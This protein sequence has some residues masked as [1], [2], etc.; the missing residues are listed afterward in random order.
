MKNNQRG[1]T[2]VETMFM[3][4]I[5]P[6]IMMAVYSVLSSANTIMSTNNVYSRLNTDA[7]QT[8]R[9]VAREIGQTSPNALPSHLVIGV[10]AGQS[11]VRFQIPVDWDNDGDVVNGSL[12]PT[13][14]WGSYS[15]VRDDTS[16][17]GDA[18]LNGWIRYSVANNQL[19]REVLDAGQVTVAGSSKVVANNVQT[20]TAVQNGSLLT[21]TVT[22]Q[23]ADR[24]EQQG[25]NQRFFT[26]TFT[27]QTTLRNA[28]N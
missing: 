20:F 15:D 24:L 6:M 3:V 18:I 16:V 25:N 17:A 12:N 1:F 4:V 27:T 2:L 9:Y 23:A 28:V 5:F 13:V 26:T 8:L 19:T 7:M 10:S 22:L 11:S 14:E 21:L